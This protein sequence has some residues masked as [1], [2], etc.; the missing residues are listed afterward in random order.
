MQV[1]KTFLNT[2]ENRGERKKKSTIISLVE[3]KSVLGS[4][5]DALTI[6]HKKNRHGHKHES[7]KTEQKTSP[8]GAHTVEHKG[9]KE[10]KDGTK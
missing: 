7:N 9:G 4:G 1:E 2:R 3:N 5:S 8:V 10:R 6:L